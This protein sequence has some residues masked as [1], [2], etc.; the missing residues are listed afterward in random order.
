MCRD[1]MDVQ[2]MIRQM[3][4]KCVKKQAVNL[5]ISLYNTIPFIFKYYLLVR[6]TVRVPGIDEPVCC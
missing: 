4:H 1:S 2:N 6:N 3:M 5:A